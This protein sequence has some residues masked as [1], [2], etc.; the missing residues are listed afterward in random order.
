MR[1]SIWFRTE[2]KQPDKS[3][4]YFTYRGWGIGGKADGDEDYGYL[5]YRKKDDTWYGYKNSWDSS[6]P[7]VVNF[8][9]YW[10]DADPSG[11][12]DKDPPSVKLRKS[13]EEHNVALD[14]AWKKV[15]EAIDQ[16]NMIKELVR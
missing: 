9:Y 11:W 10:S 14:D 7:D 4:Y 8:V 16:Y 6:F 5:Y 13:K 1:T 12:V 15:Q 2:E 3:G